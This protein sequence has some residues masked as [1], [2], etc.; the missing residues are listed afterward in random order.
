MNRPFTTQENQTE[1]VGDLRKSDRLFRRQRRAVKRRQLILRGTSV[2]PA[3]FTLG[4]G[5]LG[6]AAIH[7][8]SR[9]KLGFA[10]MEKWGDISIAAW[11]IFLAMVCDMIDGR[12]ARWARKTSDFGAQLD[13]LCDAISFGVAPAILMLRTV[14][15]AFQG[16]VER[17]SFLPDMPL[18]ERVV[19]AVAG[20]YIVCAV[21]RLARFNVEN[22]PDES[23]HMYFRGLP[24]P[25]AAATVA[26]TV[27]LFVR[28]NSISDGWRSNPILLAAVGAILPIITLITA[29]LMV[30][31]FRYSHI[32][33]QY[34]RGKKP[35]SYLVK[36]MVVLLAGAMEPFVTAAL[37]VLAY[38]LSGPFGFLV[39]KKDRTP[40]APPQL[41]PPNQI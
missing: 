10:D 30:S 28:L 21:L 33:N 18:L 13:S 23:A 26:A 8:A 16:H 41:P 27:L 19:W 2:L 38:T 1:G 22:E 6:F 20:L 24:S 31:R 14:I 32:I 40:T 37:V 34:I 7:F 11:M 35:F 12:L 39:K 36:L 5:L 29:M 9:S 17:I 25:G 4:N 15:T 3:M